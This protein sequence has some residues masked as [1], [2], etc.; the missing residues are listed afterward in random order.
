M[1]K[2]V[3]T[4]L[5]LALVTL[6]ARADEKKKDEKKD[7]LEPKALE[8]LKQVGALHKDAKSMHVEGSVVTDLDNGDGKRQIKSEIVYDL[9]RPNRFAMKTRLDGDKGAGP[10][11]VSDGKKLFVHAKRVKQYTE[12]DAS[13]GLA[14]LGPMLLQFGQANTGILFQNVLAEDPYEQLME[15]VTAASYAGKEKVNGTD[16]HHLKFEQ[17]GMNWELWIAAEGKPFVLK[18]SSGRENDNGKMTTV[19]TYKNWKVDAAPAKETFTYTPG[20]E[21]KKVDQIGRDN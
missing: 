18:A 3:F 2:L 19:E 7:P 9:E 17:P 16:T 8:I 1:R 10:D 13:K 12:D 15:G 5:T 4:A 21:S 6:L 20:T 14:D 11:V